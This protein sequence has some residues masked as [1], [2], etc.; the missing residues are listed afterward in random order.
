MIHETT[1]YLSGSESAGTNRRMD[2]TR[3]ECKS[4]KTGMGFEEGV[5][6]REASDERF[7]KLYERIERENH[8]ARSSAKSEKH[9]QRT[10]RSAENGR[11]PAEQSFE[12][13][14]EAV[15]EVKSTSTETVTD[16]KVVE[17]FLSQVSEPVKIDGE[18]ESGSEEAAQQASQ[19][20][21]EALVQIS[22]LLD[23]PMDESMG[24]LSFEQL[25]EAGCEQMAEILSVL[26][27][28]GVMLDEVATGGET[29]VLG[30][31]KIDQAAAIELSQLLRAEK[32]HLEMGLKALGVSEK[33]NELMA[34]N[35]N[36]TIDAGIPVATDP[37]DLVMSPAD[38]AKIFSNDMQDDLQ[39]AIEKIQK[40]LTTGEA[41]LEAEP[42]AVKNSVLILNAADTKQMRAALKID[43][44][45]KS[46]TAQVVKQVDTGLTFESGKAKVAPVSANQF[47]EEFKA[48]HSEKKPEPIVPSTE[49]KANRFVLPGVEPVHI[50]NADVLPDDAD[51]QFAVPHLGHATGAA[52]ILEPAE[53]LSSAISRITD[54]AI[55]RQISEKMQSAIRAG[56]H[57]VRVQLRPEALG[58]VNLRIRMEGDVVFARIQVENQ[59][60]KAIV[61]SNLQ[62]LK[63]ALEEQNLHAGT[64]SVDV[65][66][67][68]D[69]SAGRFRQDFA[70]TA[71]GI[72]GLGRGSEDSEETETASV[73]PV[74]GSDTGRRY[75]N[76]SI[77]LYI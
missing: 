67:N 44:Q 11:I 24:D 3:T 68:H 61:E 2:Q 8:T 33:V 20:L 13:K 25:D 21:N 51:A 57:E 42:E 56:V 71:S 76:N 4:E 53:K 50:Q 16:S 15:K 39:A 65:G 46:D 5:R 19:L 9:D 73:K 70:E 14:E 7:R 58:E 64:F 17:S 41:M 43:E 18:Q 52:A 10:V 49:Q 37:A 60:V 28:I 1:Q 26:E 75:G 69:G 31:M 54:E 72:T 12:P 62:S 38:T 48:S 59:Q 36:K 40:L 30:E 29:L 45:N 47:A 63:S 66:G 23:I 74:A 6:K 32:F 77:E 27:K 34:V 55:L 35:L 22:A